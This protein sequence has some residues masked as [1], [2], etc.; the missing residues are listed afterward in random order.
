VTSP[1]ISIVVPCHN[2]ERWLAAA[3]ESALAQ[4]WPDKE[5]IVVNDGSSDGSLAVARAFEQ[6]GVRV[7]DQPNRG[8]AAARN[9]GLRLAQ[10]DLIQ[11]LDADD[12]LAPDK[13]SRQMLVMSG[14]YRRLLSSSAWARFQDHPSE[15]Q[16]TPQPNWR[17][18][19]GVEFL[20]LHYESGCMMQPAAWL[21]PR[22]LLD[23]AGPWDESLSLNDDGEYFARVM[24][25]ADQIVFCAEARSYYRSGWGQSLSARQDRRSLDSLY[26]SVDLTVRHLLGIDQSPRSLAAAAHAWKWTAYELYPGAPDLARQAERHSSRLGGSTR[27][28]PMGGRARLLAQV[29]G[30]RL[31]KRIC[32]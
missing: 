30:W 5:I 11:F 28:L 3:I 31:A 27:P 24:L 21:A 1:L 22:A 19:S 15:A 4:T 10:G 16:F 18:L 25:A 6:R 7:F 9:A 29:V 23:R 20:Q 17:N 8:A 2:A 13:L 12:L 14:D 26:R 32:R